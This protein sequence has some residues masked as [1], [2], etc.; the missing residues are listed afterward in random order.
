MAT[1]LSVDQTAENDD[2]VERL[3]LEHPGE[4]F[5]IKNKRLLGQLQPLRSFG[6]IQYK[7]DKCF[8]NYAKLN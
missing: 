7:W 5:V 2:E 3:R 4:A 8:F 6:D 1:P